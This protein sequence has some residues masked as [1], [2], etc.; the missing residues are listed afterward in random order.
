M[1][2]QKKSSPK[3]LG[4]M[5]LLAG[6][7]A[8]IGYISITTIVEWLPKDLLKPQGPGERFIVPLLV[9]FAV[10][11]AI[12]FHEI[13]HLAAGLAQ[14]FRFALYTVGF[15]GVRGTSN[16]PR[17]F[18]NRNINLMGG[19]AAT[20]PDQLERGPALRRKFALI[21]AAGPVASLLLVL[22]ASLLVLAGFSSLAQT[23]SAA[24]RGGVLFA[25]MAGLFS[26]L[27]FLATMFPSR[28]GGFMSDGARIMSLLRGG[29]SSRYE[30]AILSLSTLMGAG[31]LPG[32]YPS[33][34][35]DQLKSRPANNLLGL[36]G[37]FAVFLHHLDR[38]E[39]EAALDIARQIE[40]HIDAIPNAFQAYYLKEV[41][42]F[43]AF[44]L[45]D[46]AKTTEV[47]STVSKQAE[48]QPDSALFRVKAALALLDGDT[49][50]VAELVNS[51]V[52]KIPDLPF[53]GQRRFEEKWL[54]ELSKQ[55]AP[56]ESI[57]SE[58]HNFSDRQNSIG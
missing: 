38:R 58:V 53:A 30:E 4:T 18:L 49:D 28:A 33:A 16:G 31:K 43:Y 48:R 7:G 35:L 25:L 2:K 15:L 57:R 20:Y 11:F 47:W 9:L 32:E 12:A 50:K 8:A 29:E 44:L 5:L 52:A 17:F 56:S 19:L 10:W 21:V 23:P 14:G 46:V 3:T 34:I 36:N 42:F 51:G 6:L 13:G 40:E 55:T 37:H 45:Q 26:S 22:I 39:T 1:N 54:A 41:A 27:I 24:L